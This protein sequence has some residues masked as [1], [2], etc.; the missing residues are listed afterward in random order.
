ML[1]AVR[2][3]DEPQALEIARHQ[4]TLSGVDISQSPE[5]VM[6]QF[7]DVIRVVERLFNEP[8]AHRADSWKTHSPV[9]HSRFSGFESRRLQLSA[10]TIRAALPQMG[11]IG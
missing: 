11:T 9:Y 3:R 2:H 7:I 10:S 1:A 8:K 5:A 4:T 6:L